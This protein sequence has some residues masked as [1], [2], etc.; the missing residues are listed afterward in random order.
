MCEIYKLFHLQV[1]EVFLSYAYRL[2]NLLL[3]TSN[4][5]RTGTTEESWTEIGISLTDC[6]SRISNPYG[7][8]SVTNHQYLRLISFILLHQQFHHA[9]MINIFY[10]LYIYLE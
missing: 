6:L 1:L 2:I 10:L 8:C 9:G 5:S 3:D 7:S 4:K